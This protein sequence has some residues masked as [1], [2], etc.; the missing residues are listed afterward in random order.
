M[1][2]RFRF[3]HWARHELDEAERTAQPLLVLADG[4]Y[5]TLNFWRGLPERT[6]LA[7]RTARN[8]R[9]YDLPE[10][11]IGPGRPPRYGALAPHPGE[12]LHRGLTW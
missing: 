12:W 6:I 11:S 4:G 8:R 7:V 10:P 3:L 9:L 1:G 2:S 5:N